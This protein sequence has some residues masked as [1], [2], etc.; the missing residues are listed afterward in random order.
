MAR[1]N[2]RNASRNAATIVA[3]YCDTVIW[4]AEALEDCKAAVHDLQ[5]YIVNFQKVGGSILYTPEEYSEKLA[6]LQAELDAKKAEYK[7]YYARAIEAA[8]WQG[9]TKSDRDFY[10]AYKNATTKKAQREVICKWLAGFLGVA[11]D[12]DG[13]MTLAE[14]LRGWYGYDRATTRQIVQSNSAVWHKVRGQKSVLDLSYRFLAEKMIAAQ[15]IPARKIPAI[16]RDKYAP[17][18][19]KAQ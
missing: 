19:K 5:V 15:T 6:L 16:L 10:K 8:G 13:L 3:D 1:F 7:G 12:T 9:F 11:A 14:E 4:K 18:A 17:K 2:F